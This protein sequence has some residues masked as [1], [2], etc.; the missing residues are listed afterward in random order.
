M[1]DA[2]RAVEVTSM[3]AQDRSDSKRD[4]HADNMS[5]DVKGTET[6]IPASACASAEPYHRRQWLQKPQDAT[7]QSM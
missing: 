4:A 1:A 2:L 6:D 5:H 7:P 3:A